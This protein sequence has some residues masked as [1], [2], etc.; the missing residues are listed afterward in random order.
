VIYRGS[1]MAVGFAIDA[2]LVGEAEARRRVLALWAPGATVLAHGSL[3]VIAGLRAMRV[4][5]EAAPGMPL[6]AQGSVV[7]AMPV[8]AATFAAGSIVV[9]RGGEA[10][11]VTGIPV[12]LAAWIELDDLAVLEL[13]PLAPRPAALALAPPPPDTREALA[14]P[15]A[16]P[17]GAEVRAALA[18]ALGGEGPAARPSLWQR[19]LA[20]FAPSRQRALPAGA[21]SHAPPPPPSWLAR[22]RARIAAAVWRSALGRVLGRAYAAYLQKTLDLF[23]RG[24]YDAALR[25]AISIGG[26]EPG[27]LGLLAT[28]LPKPRDRVELN[29]GRRSG[30]S[31]LVPAGLDAVAELRAAYRR[32]AA[33]LEQLGR[34]ADA[35]FVLAELLGEVLTAIDVLERHGQLE[36]AAK[37]ADARALSPG[38]RVRLWFLAGNRERAIDVARSHDAW[39]DAVQRLEAA[40]DERA[41]VLRMLWADHLADCGDY[42]AAVGVA[43]RARA[44]H[45]LIESWIDRGIAGEGTVAARLFVRKL[46]VAPASFPAVAPAVLGFLADPE[47]VQ[48]RVAFAEELIG[49]PPS[50]ELRTLARPVVRALLADLGAARPI[51]QG[52]LERLVRLA[53]DPALRIDQARLRAA[54]PPEPA[55]ARLPTLSWD[56]HD[57]GALAVH[58]VAVLPGDRLLVALGE[59]GVRIVNR[60]GKT[61][62]HIDQPAT[63]LVVSDH[64]TRALAIAKRGVDVH[65]IARL[66]LA[67]KRGAHWCDAT[68]DSA[69]DTFDGDTWLVARGREVFAVDTTGD[70]WRSMWGI[71]TEPIERPLQLRR[72]QTCWAIE[73]FDGETTEC[74]YYDRFALHARR[75]VA[76]DNSLV[77]ALPRARI[78]M[79][80]PFDVVSAV[81]DRMAASGTNVVSVLREGSPIALVTLVLGGAT[82]SSVRLTGGQLAIGDDRG[83][84]LVY[85]VA[86]GLLRHDLRLS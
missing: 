62:A 77:V 47:A 39:G 7:A 59:L 42:M 35:A 81:C 45:A 63:R 20:W 79:K 82:R 13:A 25:H 65:R 12:G 14:A 58:D 50:P 46:V 4:R 76:H 34:Y 83:R 80:L 11:V 15:P 52:L 56:A 73:A 55:P 23:E 86:A 49:E 22:L 41:A 57:A 48:S 19:I 85:D 69:V 32:A 44:S 26:D 5:C 24:D 30:A 37:L 33:R 51:K 74:W 84:V 28:S 21:P 27:G 61:V 29:L 10:H 36:T 16:D 78:E 2:A 40:H 66:D 18:R 1:V 75:H 3:Y 17:L 60:A 8:D 72:D 64:G 67:M 70:R 43:W 68:F 71:Q 6:V 53:D 38:L 31:S 9:A 54:P